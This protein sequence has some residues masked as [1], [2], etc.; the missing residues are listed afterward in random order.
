MLKLLLALALLAGLGAAFALAPL[1]GRTMLDRW[2]ASR[3][4]RDFLERGL[5]E[6]KASFGAE[7]QRPHPARAASKPAR[8]ARPPRPAER[9][10]EQDRAALDRIVAEHAVDR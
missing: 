5:I 6:A 10:T 9:H 2:H 1:H 4:P 7:A 3:S 8:P